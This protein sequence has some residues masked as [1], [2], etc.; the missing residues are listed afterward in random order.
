MAS[1]ALLKSELHT[2]VAKALYNE[3]QSN[4][5]HYYYF[6]GKTLAWPVETQPPFPVDSFNY[7]LQTRSEIITLKEINPTDVAFIVERVNWASGTI[8]DQYDDHLCDELDGINLIAGGY[9]YSDVPTVTITGGGGSGATAQAV[10]ANGVVVAINM[11]TAGRGYVSMPT[12]S[13]TGGGG[14]NAQATGILAQASSGAAQVEQAN[15]VVITDEYNVYK[16]LDNNNNAISTYKPIGTVVDPV[17]M[18]DGYM[19][20]YLY[21]IPIALRNKF[22]TDVTCQL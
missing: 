20:K 9:G 12:V 17:I 15:M 19:W 3:I 10:V 14:L 11:L 4:S 21:S 13:I 1:S 16:C 5:S 18:P 7:E 6:L 8:Y 2:S 22:L